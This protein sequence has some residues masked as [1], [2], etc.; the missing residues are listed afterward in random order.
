VLGFTL[1]VSL[2]TAGVFG[3]LPALTGSRLDL[4]SALKDGTRV[5]SGLGRSRLRA[6]LVVVNLAVALVLLAGAGLAL[7]SVARLAEVD[8]GFQPHHLLTMQMSAN[9]PRYRDNAAVVR[10]LHQVRDNVGTIAG[11]ESVA[12]ASQIPM[13]RNIDYW[14]ITIEG[15]PWDNP[16]AAPSAERY[17]VTPQYFATLGVPLRS[18]RL[19]GP[20][21]DAGKPPVVVINEAFARALFPGEDPIGKRILLGGGPQAPWRTIVG[22]V[23]DL[24]HE[25]LEVPPPL[26]AYVP[27]DQSADSYVTL[28]IRSTVDP[29]ALAAS[30]ARTVRAVDRDVPVWSVATMDQLLA[31]T[32]AQRRF[33]MSLLAGFAALALALAIVGIYS[34]MAYAVAQRTHEI[35]VR[36]ALGALR[37]DVVRMVVREG[38]LLVAIGVVSGL[39]GVAALSRGVR[40]VLY[41]VSATDP[42]ILALVTALLAAASLLACYLP[43]RRATRVDPMEALRY[44]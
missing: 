27:I 37:G 23:G 39:A 14:G 16:A 28:V 15:R 17:G 32:L 4:N 40:S 38:G 42:A 8:P 35:G 11:V 13:G 12:L 5:S 29:T 31:G 3:M 41:D 18:G 6:A 9:G 44:E 1:A 22:V 25:S 26:Q 34:V 19:V 33:V 10:F 43:A 20:Q 2:L 21:D 24:H 30:V 36:I 7:K